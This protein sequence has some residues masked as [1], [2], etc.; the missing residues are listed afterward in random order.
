MFHLEAIVKEKVFKEIGKGAIEYS[1]KEPAIGVK[2]TVIVLK[3]L[4]RIGNIFLYCS[5]TIGFFI[6]VPKYSLICLYH[7]AT[8][9]ESWG[10]LFLPP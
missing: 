9:C 8:L 4:G 3:T 2:F 6:D 7:F 5:N 1:L 10:F